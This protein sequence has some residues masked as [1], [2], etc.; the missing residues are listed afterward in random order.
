[1]NK[2]FDIL[3]K[4]RIVLKNILIVL[5]VAVCG[6]VYCLFG[7]GLFKGIYT[8]EE[9]A[10]VNEGWENAKVYEEDFSD[11]F[12]ENSNQEAEIF[13]YICGAVSNPGVYT[14]KKQTRLYELIDMAGGFLDE[15]DKEYLNLVTYVS[16]GEKIYV[17]SKSEVVAGYDAHNNNGNDS[18]YGENMQ[19][20]GL[21]IDINKADAAT[22]MTLPGIGEARARDIVEYRSN[23]GC[24]FRI[25][26]IMKVSGIKEAAYEK[27][28]DYIKV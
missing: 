4:H 23:N 16:D 13:V 5:I 27:I 1:M 12:E 10:T 9:K 15:A 2:I 20:S 24:F 26:D 21:K 8:K 3:S 28:K 18:V 17:P 6:V 11:C 22:L 7:R 14:C 19:N 25:E